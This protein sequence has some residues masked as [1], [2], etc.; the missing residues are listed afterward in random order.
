MYCYGG[1]TQCIKTHK[2]NVSLS[3]CGTD[4]DAAADT[5]HQECPSGTDDECPD[6]ESCWG[7]SPCALL[8]SKIEAMAA[9][10]AN[11]WCGTN[12]KMLVEQCPKR[13]EGGTDDECGKD[14]DGNDMICFDMSTEE[15]VCNM[16]GVGIKEPTD[17]DNLW[18]GT[19]WNHGKSNA[20]CG[21]LCV[22][23]YIIHRISLLNLHLIFPLY[24]I[25]KQFFPV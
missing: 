6:G 4:S 2:V 18:C 22:V 9:Q 23:R 21:G 1:L 12:Y 14:A 17:P 3:W 8:D 24:L 16:T 11:L 19:S 5:C 10:A 20:E 13:C 15:T 25:G 7:D